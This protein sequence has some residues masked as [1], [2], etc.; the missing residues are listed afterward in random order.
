M[1]I[2]GKAAI[3]GIGELPSQRQ[4]PDRTTLGLCAEAARLAIEDAGL[5]KE[6]VNGLVTD[7]GT[8][9]AAMAEY[10]SLRPT[11]ATGVAMQGASGASATAVAASAVHAGYCDTVL[12]VM[13]NSRLD[14]ARA[15]APLNAVRSEWE[16]P[17]GM[18]AGANTGYGLMYVRHMHEY[19]TKPEQ[20]AKMAADQRFNALKNPN[21][22]FKN[23]PITAE[24]VLNSRYI[25]YPLR[26]LESVM[27]CDGAAACIVTTPERARALPNRPVYLL[28]VG[29]E[30]G[31]ANVWQTPRAT[32][33]PVK[34]SAARAFQ[35]AGYRPKDIQFAEF[36]D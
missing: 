24:D 7:G 22:V 12:V 2:R 35:M 19:G 8:T 11:F 3:V 33:T 26:L 9:P 28:G 6:D 17:Y 27:P 32:T 23:Q 1:T 21:A 16:V 31:A 30:Q 25:S 13:G 4:Y 36:Y 10:I 29:M 5:R 14:R 18:A 20:M 34:V 15:G